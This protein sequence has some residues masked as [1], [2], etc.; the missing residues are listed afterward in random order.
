MKKLIFLLTLFLTVFSVF[1]QSQTFKI[2]GKLLSESDQ[3][4]LESATIYLERVKDSSLVTYTISD[5]EGGFKIEDKT[6]D[7]SLNLTI[8]YIGFQPFTKEIQIDKAL[9]NLGVIKLRVSN[10]LDEVVIKS[11]V[12]I[13]IKK[14]TLEFNVKSFKT[15][16]DANVE[17]LLKQ[18][19]GVEVDEQGK[20]TVNGKEV[21]K[22]LVN[23][24][25]FFGNDPTIT[26]RNL[27]KDI[28]EKIQ[29]VD[30]KTKSEAL[31]GEKG[32]QENKT[33]NLTIKEENNK[34]VFGRLSAGAGTDERYEF[35][36]MLN[37]FNNDRRMSVLVGGNNINSP[38]FSFGE[39]SK[40][41]GRSGSSSFSSNGSFSIDGRSF[42]GG[43][44]ITTSRNVGANYADV[45][46]KKNDLSA[47]YFHSSSQSDNASSSQRETTLSDSRF[48]S[49]SNS[50]TINETNSHSVNM[51]YDI[52][53]DSTFV[54][55]IEPS[56]RYSKTINRSARYNETL[57]EERTLT[58]QSNVDTD[59]ER[60]G[61]T[62]TNDLTI[63]K[64]FGNRGAFVR[65][66]IENEITNTESD[67]F[68]NST[69]QIFGDNPELIQRKQLTDGNGKSTVF[70]SEVKYR[71]PIVAKKLFLDFEY[72]YRKAIDQDVR[73]T[74]DFDDVTN[75][76]NQF[77]TTLSTDFEYVNIEQIP[78]ISLRFND[79][80][81]YASI[82]ADY[83]LRTLEN[84]DLLRPEFNIKQDFEAL[85]LSGYVNYRFSEKSSIYSGYRLRNRPPTLRQL[86]AFEDVSNPLNTVVG[87]PNLQP[88][89][90]HRLYVGFNSYDFQK[91]SGLFFYVSIDAQ[92]DDV[93][94]KTTIDPESL[95]RTTTYANVNGNYR[96]SFSTSYSKNIKLD[97]IRKLR[98]RL[99]VWA[100]KSRNINFNNDVQ[101][102]SET[103]SF[104][105]NVGLEF[106]WKK[107]FDIKPSYRLN[108]TNNTF[109]IDAFE[110]REFLNHNL[111]IKTTTYLPKRFEWI[112]DIRYNYNPNV[113][114]GFQKSA[115]FWNT[116]LAYSMLKDKAA[117]TLKVY[118][119]LNQ[120]TNARRRA[121]S[122]YIEDLQSTVL[123][124]YFML[125]FSWKFNSL[126]SKGETNS[127]DFYIID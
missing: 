89:D 26:T 44:G 3:L 45:I 13:T 50:N 120:N 111:S 95:K 60:F 48:F 64:K 85:Q 119:L 47:D 88:T 109:D 71:Y 118:D 99:G 49:N 32:S 28:I 116:S 81:W 80:K 103:T 59:I 78:A 21:N 31:T 11:R 41:F 16:K 12:P 15:K 117:L 61:K 127:S 22:I 2:Q 63:T 40:M 91:R 46:N 75:T 122:D 19:P 83:V 105:P 25:P 107:I 112:N 35:A 27:T 102:A 30:T 5:K 52:K 57:D 114:D 68:L 1:S 110:D 56:F 74:F 17:D 72:N 20:I 124:Q 9:I 73:S 115:W 125:S 77:N 93:V 54:I 98:V 66:G 37:R 29:V 126:G 97:S 65:F 36:G 123:Q 121:T 23:G 113:A 39:I 10:Q 33:I 8:S 67:D 101:Y 79:E 42:G 84:T 6:Y 96:A 55:N 34:G 51:E 53:I 18:L 92:D 43:E 58:N 14:D 87:N 7:K 70:E 104:T 24:K 69:T 82:G 94:S 108:I 100:N 90:N 106:T 4:P 76:Y 62:F 86:Q 38:G